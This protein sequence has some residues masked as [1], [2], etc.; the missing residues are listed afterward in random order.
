V[1][2]G[3]GLGVLFVLDFNRNEFFC[4]FSWMYNGWRLSADDVFL[5][6]HSIILIDPL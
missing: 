2:I 5:G 3:F 1:S 4:I 6:G